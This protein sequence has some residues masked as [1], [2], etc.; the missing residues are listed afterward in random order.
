V[1]VLRMQIEHEK[2]PSMYGNESTEGE[3]L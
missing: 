1:G 2:S 3:K